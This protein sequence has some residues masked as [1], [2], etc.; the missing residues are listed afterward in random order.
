MI[1][2][3]R[4]IQLLLGSAC[5]LCFAAK[6][7]N[8]TSMKMLT[9]ERNRINCSFIEY[10]ENEDNYCRVV[11]LWEFLKH[12]KITSKNVSK[13]GKC[14]YLCTKHVLLIVVRFIGCNVFLR[15]PFELVFDFLSES[16]DIFKYHPNW[17]KSKKYSRFRTTFLH[18]WSS[19]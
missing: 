16:K 5:W 17:E 14:T 18:A 8:W 12:R 3:S 11:L 9:I 1:H 7:E 2:L 6:R 10:N 4:Y 15:F 13:I 19:L